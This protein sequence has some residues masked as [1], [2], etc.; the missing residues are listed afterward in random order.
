MGEHNEKSR[1][2]RW[3]LSM[4]ML[5]DKPGEDMIKL[6]TPDGKLV[7]VSRSVV[8]EAASKQK[9]GNKEIFQWMNN[10]SKEQDK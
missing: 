7:Q 1:S 5:K 9:A 6:L 3:F 4:G 2:R 8:D 10:P